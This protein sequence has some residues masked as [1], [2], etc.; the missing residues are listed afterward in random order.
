LQFTATRITKSPSVSKELD[1]YGYKFKMNF[2]I[3]IALQIH[4]SSKNI[5]GIGYMQEPN[6]TL[7]IIFGITDRSA[8]EHKR[9]PL[10][11]LVGSTGSLDLD[12][13]TGLSK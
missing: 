5:N 10:N 4:F 8:A 7:L 12:A 9:G 6:R 3:P 2:V 11:R 1:N 13:F